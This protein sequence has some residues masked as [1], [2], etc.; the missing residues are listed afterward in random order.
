MIEAD[1]FEEAL[2]LLRPMVQ[3]QTVEPN[4]LFLEGLAVIGGPLLR[5]N[6]TEVERN[7]LLD[8]AIAALQAQCW[9]TIRACCT[10]DFGWPLAACEPI[11]SD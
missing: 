2:V 10:R 6:R 3:G 4:T 5:A 9:S 1:R 11:N 7:A 8:E